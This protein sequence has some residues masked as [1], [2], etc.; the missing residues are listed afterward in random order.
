MISVKPFLTPLV[1]TV[2][3]ILFASVLIAGASLDDVKYPVK[4]LGNCKNEEDCLRYCE[5]RN[6][7]ERVKSCISFAKRYELL[8]PAE[9]KEAEYYV[10]TLGVTKGPGECRNQKECDLYCENT[11]HFNECLDFA[12]KYA[13]SSPEEIVE[14]RKI[15]KALGEVADLPGGCKTKSE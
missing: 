4:E 12:E 9:L 6:G 14:G 5:D 3:A 15:A 11:T 2:S 8:S 7:L 10:F 13:L 1:I